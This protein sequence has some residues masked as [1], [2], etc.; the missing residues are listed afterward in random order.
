MTRSEQKHDVQA[1]IIWTL[2]NAVL[3]GGI[4]LGAINTYGIDFEMSSSFRTPILVVFGLLAAFHAIIGVKGFQTRHRFSST[5]TRSL[6]FYDAVLI[7]VPYVYLGILIS[8]SGRLLTAGYFSATGPFIALLAVVLTGYGLIVLSNFLL[9]SVDSAS[10]AG[11][12]IA[13]RVIRE[14]ILHQRSTLAR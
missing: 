11:K 10:S 2:F 9:L 14:R 8:L 5:P 7:A 13:R 4:Y 3:W 12:E 1:L 6:T